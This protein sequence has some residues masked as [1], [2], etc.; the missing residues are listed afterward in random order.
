MTMNIKK[1]QK[2]YDSVNLKPDPHDWARQK[3]GLR[4]KKQIAKI[5]EKNKCFI[6]VELNC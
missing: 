5:L 6:M 3:I 1:P 2:P 4:N